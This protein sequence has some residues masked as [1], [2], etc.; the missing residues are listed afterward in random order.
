MEDNARYLWSF[1][2]STSANLKL[3][4]FTEISSQ[5]FHWMDCGAVT[6]FITVGLM[7]YSTECIDFPSRA[8]AWHLQFSSGISQLTSAR[9]LV[10]TPQGGRPIPRRARPDEGGSQTP[11]GG[12]WSLWSPDGERTVP[13][14][15]LLPAPCCRMAGGSLQAGFLSLFDYKT[16][17]YIVA[18]NKRVGVL[19]RLIQLSIIGYI[20]G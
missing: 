12:R 11:A 18:Q 4:N 5:V 8:W 7:Y 14:H 1:C 6:P 20:I 9:H 17:K 19:Y 3:L 13:V 10:S 2:Q 15:C 16:E